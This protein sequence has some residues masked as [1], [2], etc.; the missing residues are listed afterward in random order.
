GC[1]GGSQLL[2]D[3]FKL[4][5]FDDVADLILAKVSQLDSAFQTRPH[6]LHVVLDSAQRG[7]SAVVNWLPFSHHP[8][9]RGPRN[10]AIS[11]QATGDDAF[12]QLE[13]LF[14]FRVA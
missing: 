6:F 7:D 12:A 13:N 11:D 8:R 10:A 14:H 5:T 9:A 1:A 2:S 3:G 4:I